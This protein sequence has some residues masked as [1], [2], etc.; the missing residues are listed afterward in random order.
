MQLAKS[1]VTPDQADGLSVT[2]KLLIIVERMADGKKA[3]LPDDEP[4]PSGYTY[5]IR[6]YELTP[7]DENGE[8]K[9]VYKNLPVLNRGSLSGA[10]DQCNVKQSDPSGIAANPRGFIVLQEIAG[11]SHFLWPTDQPIP[12]GF[13]KVLRYKSKPCFFEGE[14]NT[15]CYGLPILAGQPSK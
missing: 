14:L 15:K 7:Y 10:A 11:Q 3:L 13:T 4:L 2:G 12:A 9:K 1:G 6:R 5:P 8:L